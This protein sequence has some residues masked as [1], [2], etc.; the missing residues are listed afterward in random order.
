MGWILHSQNYSTPALFPTLTV[1]YN[2]ASQ[3]W[4]LQ[5]CCLIPTEGWG[6]GWHSKVRPTLWDALELLFF[7]CRKMGFFFFFTIFFLNCIS[8][9]QFLKWRISNLSESCGKAINHF[10]LEQYFL[11]RQVPSCHCRKEKTWILTLK[12]THE[13]Q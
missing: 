3:L 7:N 6:L 13:G 4:G 9:L 5:P 12:L 2:T 1:G 8:Q 11:E 10:L